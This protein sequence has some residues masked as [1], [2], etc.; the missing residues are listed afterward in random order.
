MENKLQIFDIMRKPSRFT[1]FFIKMQKVK[2]F[3]Y[4]LKNK[5]KTLLMYRIFI[6]VC[7][8]IPQWICILYMVN[9]IDLFYNQLFSLGTLYSFVFSKGPILFIIYDFYLLK[10]IF[11]KISKKEV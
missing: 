5:S 7:V 1:K 9:C 3:N 2:L 11:I 6:I 10:Q 8:R 4:I